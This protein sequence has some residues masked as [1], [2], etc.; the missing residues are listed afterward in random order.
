MNV[1]GK[2]PL[3]PAAAEEEKDEAGEKD[4]EEKDGKAAPGAP[5]APHV[6]ITRTPD[7]RLTSLL[8]LG[9]RRKGSAGGGIPAAFTGH[10]MTGG[11]T[12]CQHF[13]TRIAGIQQYPDAAVMPMTGAGHWCG[14]EFMLAVSA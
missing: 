13:L 1:L 9:S 3:P 11:C 2:T 12:G 4:P 7:G 10:L 8:A 6:L 14:S 5:G